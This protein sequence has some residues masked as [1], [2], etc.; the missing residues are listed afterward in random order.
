MLRMFYLICSGGHFY[1]YPHFFFNI[2][3]FIWLHEVLVAAHRVLDFHFGK[4]DLL[5]RHSNSYFLHVGSSSLARN[6]TWSC[7]IQSAESQPLNHQGSPA[8]EPYIPPFYIWANWG[9]EKLRNSSKIT[10]EVTTGEGLDQD[11]L[12]SPRPEAF[13]STLSVSPWKTERSA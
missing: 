8:T 4:W 11:S 2:Y 12:M 6:Q 7:C 1:A 5:L 3:L 9:T 13:Y 10:Y